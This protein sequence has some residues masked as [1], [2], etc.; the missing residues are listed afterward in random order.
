MCPAPISAQSSTGQPIVIQYAVTATFGAPPVTI[1]C[2]PPNGSAFPVGST[3]VTCTATD[4]IRRTDFCTF[5]ITVTSPPRVSLTSFVAFG[6][7]ITAGEI[8]TEGDRFGFRTLLV[9]FARSYPTD[10]LN[11]LAGYYTAQA[12]SIFVSNQGFS[13]ETTAQGVGRLS[14][15][16]G[17]ARYQALL[18]MEGANDLQNT[19]GALGNIQTMVHYGKSQGLRVFLA[20][21]PP[22][23]PNATGSC[24]A[25][26]YDRGV[27]AALVAP[28]NNG[29]STIA[30]TEAIPLVDIYQ[31]F[32]GT[33]SPDLIDCDGLHP[34]AMGYQLIADTFFRSIKVNL[35]IPTTTSSPLLRP[36]FAPPR[37][38]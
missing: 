34:T 15:V 19:A 22:E 9:D 14:R 33:A 2:V 21:L 38:K 8:I 35:S 30:S 20:T 5:G 16:L 36:V 25:G 11:D 3:P 1:S 13:G 28:Y 26:A 37:P 29:L 27:N 7:S 4:L 10:L 31:A 18:L 6:D 24:V 32:G 17:A 12:Q 23:N